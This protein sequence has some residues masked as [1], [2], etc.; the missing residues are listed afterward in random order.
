MA[1]ERS[2]VVKLFADPRQLI[3]G[4]EEV[5]IQAGKQFGDAKKSIADLSDV[6]ER[7]TIASAAAFAGLA[8]F[9]GKAVQAAM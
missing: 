5:R 7:V 3:K 9:A 6:F 4:F 1:G 2:F 8:A